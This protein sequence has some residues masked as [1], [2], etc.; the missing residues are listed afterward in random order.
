MSNN[1][2]YNA[3]AALAYI[4]AIASFLFYMPKAENSPDTI[5]VPVAMLSLFVLSASVMGYLF[6]YEPLLQIFEGRKQAGAAL[7]LKTVGIFALLTVSSLVLLFAIT[8]VGLP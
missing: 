5:L 1:P 3:A 2:L 4:V 7:F 8:G 6:L